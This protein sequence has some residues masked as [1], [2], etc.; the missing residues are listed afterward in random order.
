MEKDLLDKDKYLTEIKTKSKKSKVYKDYQMTG[1]LIAEILRD[2]KYK[3]LY[4]KLA[5][6]HNKE[7]LLGLAKSVAENK[8]V[9]NMGAYFM[10]LVT[11]SK[12]EDKNRLL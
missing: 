8:N 6:M 3:S 11:L 12:Q 7:K 9:M 5:K 10:K 1:L 2:Q 4:I